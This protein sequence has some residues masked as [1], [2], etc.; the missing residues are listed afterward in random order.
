[1]DAIRT[2]G[3]ISKPGVERG[4]TLVPEIL[5]WLAARGI[6]ARYDRETAAYVH[7]TDGRPR[8]EVPAGCQFVIVL[9]G[10]GPGGAPGR[11][12]GRV[13]PD[14]MRLTVGETYRIRVIDIMPDWTIRV[15]MMREDT[16]VHWKA[17]AKDGAELPAHAQTMRPAALF[18]GPGE[19][20][21]FEYTPA[22]PGLM[23]FRV[24]HRVDDWMTQLPITPERV[25]QAIRAR[26]R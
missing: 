22:A 11:I 23:L 17:F 18:A 26:D 16:T 3:I 4:R 21:D 2:V 24:R 10:D 20:M 9:G 19:T 15:A 12:N 7:R 6:G 1:M 14:T 8:I 13:Q 25:L 5:E